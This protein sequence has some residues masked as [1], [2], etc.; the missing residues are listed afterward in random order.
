M[1]ILYDIWI[2][3]IFEEWVNLFFSVL[4]LIPR[5]TFVFAMPPCH[6]EVVA[7]FY[8]VGMPRNLLE[9]QLPAEMDPLETRTIHVVYI[10]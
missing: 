3:G 10:I 7:G 4:Q 5:G 8:Q 1:Y 2:Y 6:F 9:T